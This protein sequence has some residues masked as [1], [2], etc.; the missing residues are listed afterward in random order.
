MGL[1]S[2]YAF[3]DNTVAS[4]CAWGCLISHSLEYYG[5]TNVVKNTIGTN[6]TH[7]TWDLV[8]HGW[9]SY[10]CF[11]DKCTKPRSSIISYGITETAVVLD[12]NTVAIRNFGKK[13]PVT[14]ANWWY[15][16]CTSSGECGGAYVTIRCT[17]S[18]PACKDLSDTTPPP[19]DTSKYTII[20][21]DKI[22]QCPLTRIL[23]PN[24][25][26]DVRAYCGGGKAVPQSILIN[27]SKATITWIGYTYTCEQAVCSILTPANVMP[28]VDANWSY[29]IEGGTSE[30]SPWCTLNPPA[31]CT[32][33]AP[34]RSKETIAVSGNTTFVKGI[35]Y[36]YTCKSGSCIAPISNTI[37]PPAPPV[38]FI[39]TFTTSPATITSGQSS[40]LSWTSNATACIINANGISRAA[41]GTLV[42][43]P[44]STTQYSIICSK[45]WNFSEPKTVIVTVTG[46][47]SSWTNSTTNPYASALSSAS[48]NTVNTWITKNIKSRSTTLSSENYTKFIET[49]VTRL[50]Q[51]KATTPA[52][53]GNKLNVINYLVWE[54]QQILNES[55][56]EWINLWWII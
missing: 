51:I 53:N 20:S 54:L 17:I 6:I 46:V 1:A 56:F 11:G 49:I 36:S 15:Y 22:F 25:Y 7:T 2:I 13:P 31:R 34:D 45:N 19:E 28:K 48:K 41:N 4:D 32:T 37:T 14:I 3:Q 43:S 50:N 42:V 27:W 33:V 30:M 10:V 47:T 26:N 44:T 35:S 5:T 29:V 39:A 8:D 18:D 23:D 9:F 24:N 38:P 55:I 21:F 52:S 16:K 12:S 40:T